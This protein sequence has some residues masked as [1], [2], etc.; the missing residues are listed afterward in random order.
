MPRGASVDQRILKL[1]D[2]S[3]ITLT[4]TYPPP[5]P[6]ASGSGATSAPIS[7]LTGPE[8]S[9]TVVPAAVTPSKPSDTMNC[10]WLDMPVSVRETL[11]RERIGIE[12]VGWI[13]QVEAVVRVKISDAAVDPTDP[14]GPTVFTDCMYVLCQGHQYRV[15][16][17]KPIGSSFRPPVSYYV[18]LTGSVSQ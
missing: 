4:V 11:S 18:F 1:I 2:E 7:P 9:Y 14:L 3:L 17:T 6:A 12:S 13:D 10:L 15:L 16:G 8:P 5:R